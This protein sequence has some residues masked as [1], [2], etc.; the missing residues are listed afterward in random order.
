MFDNLGQ[1]R[2]NY[3]KSLLDYQAGRT[4][5]LNTLTTASFFGGLGLVVL[6]AMLVIINDKK[7]MGEHTNSRLNNIFTVAFT[8]AIS[9]LSLILAVVSFT[10]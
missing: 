3:E 4:E 8:V 2:S 9:A 6:V 5:A 1:I 7:V 10:G